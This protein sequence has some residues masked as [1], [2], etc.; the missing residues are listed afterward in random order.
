MKQALTYDDILL[1]PQYSDIESR[2][3]VVIGNYLGFGL[4]WKNMKVKI[5]CI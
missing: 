5:R 3:E 1:V 4:K 2:Q